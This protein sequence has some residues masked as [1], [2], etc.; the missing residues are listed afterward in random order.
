MTLLK[1][2][3][4]LDHSTSRVILLVVRVFLVKPRRDFGPQLF[5]R[6]LSSMPGN[7]FVDPS[8]PDEPTAPFFVRRVYARSPTATVG[9]PTLPSTGKPAAIFHETNKV[10][11]HITMPNPRFAGRSLSTN[12]NGW[13]AEESHLGPAARKLHHACEDPVL[14]DEFQNRSVFRFQLPFGI[15][16]L[17]KRSRDGHFCRRSQ[18]VA[19]NLWKSRPKLRD[20]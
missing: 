10:T 8:A 4:A 2:P 1:R 16:A 13:T 3:P 6:N 19:V 17:D 7:V 18:D 11:Q 5:T 14:E 12:F 20:A 9:E 15:N